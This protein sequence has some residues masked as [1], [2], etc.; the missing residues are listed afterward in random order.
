MKFTFTATDNDGTH[1]TQLFETEHIDTIVEHME[2]FLRGCGYYPR[3]PLIID[4]FSD[5]LLEFPK[6]FEVL[7][8]A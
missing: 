4:E 8:G 7:D 2:H 3:G 6:E 5:N 1:I